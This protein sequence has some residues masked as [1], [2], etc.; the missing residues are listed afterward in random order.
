[1]NGTIKAPNVECDS[2]AKYL[3]NKVGKERVWKR[4]MKEGKESR[5]VYLKNA[6]KWIL[7][8]ILLDN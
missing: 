6:V 4:G 5:Q 3:L 7:D 2:E 8:Q 1:M